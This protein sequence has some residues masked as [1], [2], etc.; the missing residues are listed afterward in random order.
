MSFKI[1]FIKKYFDNDPQ[2]FVYPNVVTTSDNNTLYKFIEN[3][4][5][6][7]QNKLK[8]V[9]YVHD[10]YDTVI[11]NLTQDYIVLHTGI[12]KSK[13]LNNHFSFPYLFES[14]NVKFEPIQ[15]IKP[16]I[17]FCGY[18]LSHIERKKD[19]DFFIAN[20]DKIDTNFILLNKFW[21][22]K[23]HD[24]D[25]V[26]N[27]TINMKQSTFNLCTRGNGNFSMRFYQTL[28]CGRIPVFTDT[29]MELPF[30]DVI[31]YDSFCVF[32]KDRSNLLT[33]ILNIY[34]T[35]DIVEMQNLAYQTYQNYFSF[36]EYPNKLK[37][38]IIEP[39]LLKIKNQDFSLVKLFLFGN[40]AQDCS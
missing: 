39:Y 4:N 19:I 27:F 13:K 23:P 20:K 1:D 8:I 25:L 7:P 18:Y 21:G 31:D 26:K 36:E 17:S 10:L 33:K 40:E 12:I 11:P 15:N 22:G 3:I 38:Y 6:L 28:S 35:R 2:V 30:G 5:S 16:S 9:V 24:P 29:D 37:Q 34:N 14:M 32:D